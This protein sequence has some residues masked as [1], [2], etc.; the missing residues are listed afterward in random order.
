MFRRRLNTE[1]RAEDKHLNEGAMCQIQNLLTQTPKEHLVVTD[2]SPKVHNAVLAA[3]MTTRSA[4]AFRA[5]SKV[6]QTPEMR[7]AR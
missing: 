7:K 6:A 3:P 4:S 1:L 2:S 5:Q